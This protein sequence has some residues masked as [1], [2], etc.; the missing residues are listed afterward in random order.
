MLLFKQVHCF[1][2][3]RVYKSIVLQ[4]KYIIMLYDY[5]KF[6]PVENLMLRQTHDSHI[7]ECCEVVSDFI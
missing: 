3:V 7:I 6:T 4:Q 2:H 5:E 1:Y